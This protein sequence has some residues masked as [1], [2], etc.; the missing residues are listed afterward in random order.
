[1]KRVG[2]V[3]GDHREAD[4]KRRDPDTGTEQLGRQQAHR[5]GDQMAAISARGCARSPSCEPITSTN[6]GGKRNATSGYSVRVEKISIAAIAASRRRHRHASPEFGA[7]DH[8]SDHAT[9][10]PRGEA[11]CRTPRGPAKSMAATLRPPPIEETGLRD[12]LH[13]GVDR[14]VS[15]RRPTKRAPHQLEPKPPVLIGEKSPVNVAVDRW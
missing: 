15:H 6:R 4:R 2:Q 13:V 5:G 14:E 3:H 9:A 8:A 12:L 1:M 11:Q 10:G 7:R